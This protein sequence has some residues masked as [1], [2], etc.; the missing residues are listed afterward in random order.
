MAEKGFGVKEV[1]LIG[2]SGTPTITSPNN[3]NLNA[4]NVAISTNVSIGGTL[5]VTGNISIGGTLTYEDV[6]NVD[7]VGLVTARE[8]IFIPDSKELKIG[9]TAGSPDLKIFHDTNNSI[10]ANATGELLINSSIINLRDTSNNSRFRI[11]SNGT[12]TFTGDVSIADKIVHTG[13]TDTAIRF[14]QADTIRFET[15]GASRLIL[16]SGNV[17]QQSGTFIVKN[18][19]GDSN[20]IKIS[21]E[22]SDES[23][24]FNHFSGPLTFGTAN[25]ERMRINPGGNIG[26]STASIT[27]KL[28]VY[29]AGNAGGV[30]FENPH[31]VTSVSG[32][33]AANS[34]PHNI[35]LSNYENGGTD[36]M[37]TIG[38]DITTGG[39][40]AHANAVIAYQATGSGSGDLQLHMENGNVISEKLR[41]TSDSR[42]LI[43]TSSNR[44]TRLGSNN[45]SPDIQLESD[46]IGAMSLTRW[47]NGT[48]PGR[49]IL[50]KGRG[51]IASPAIVQDNDV[52]GQIIFSCWDGDTF[53]NTAQI[54]SEVDGTPGDDD[55]PGN[56]IF[57]TTS[58]GAS[59]TTQRLRI[60]RNGQLVLS[61]GN[62]STSYAASI[63]GGTNLEFDSTGVIKFRNATNQKASITSNGLCFGTDTAAANALDDYE[64]GSLNWKLQKSDESDV[65]ADVGSVVRYVKVGRLVH[66]SGRVRT[67]GTGSSGNGFF[68]FASG[69]T[70]PFTP[71]TNGTSVIGHF[72]SQDQIDSSLTASIAWQ[73]GSTTI[74]IYTIDTRADYT[75]STNNVPVSSQTNLVMTF[76]F[77]YRASA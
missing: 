3:L 13:D 70:L 15:G 50:Q 65:G 75:A 72:R 63:V 26:I 62:L 30:R 4:V 8:G 55:M 22:S 35:L 41:V 42:I 56:L 33:T 37:A 49:L 20:G 53:T 17:I 16:T 36:R 24:I 9:N 60:D 48:N 6:T 7:S 14:N 77:T 10:I 45:F 1:N 52:A 54:R 2:A 31:Q 59:S 28:H 21:Q 40:N 51:T 68:Q 27:H 25:T 34:F 57:A 44:I 67:D 66:I 76:S 46:S 29:G 19:T 73:A 58:D 71:E 64:E 74:Y 39:S 38:F 23:R 43:G 69:S 12:G 61:N 32:N 5:S 11:D 47:Q 18:A